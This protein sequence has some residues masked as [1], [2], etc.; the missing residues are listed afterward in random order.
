[1]CRIADLRAKEVINIC[2]GCRLGYVYDVEIDVCTGKLVSIIVPGPSKFFGLFPKEDYVIS[3]CE[4]QKIGDD[5][6][7]VNI[8]TSKYIKPAPKKC[9]RRVF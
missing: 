9:R 2:D 5:I 8:D 3:W 4:I 6:I 7:L 1:M